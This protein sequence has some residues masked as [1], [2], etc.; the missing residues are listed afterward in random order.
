MKQMRTKWQDAVEEFLY[1]CQLRALSKKTLKGYRNNPRRFFEVM[2]I[3]CVQDVTRTD[4]KR[5]VMQ[6]TEQGRKETYING[7]LKTLRVFFEYLEEEQLIQD[8]PMKGVKNQ[9]GPQPM[10]R[11]LT[12]REAKRMQAVFT[13]RNYL[14][15]RNKTM[16][17]VLLDTGIRNVEICNLKVDDIRPDG[18]IY[19]YGKGKKERYVPVTPAVGKALKRYLR[20]R[21][22]RIEERPHHQ[23]EWL[24]MSQKG[25][26]LTTETIENVVR[27]CGQKAKV[28]ESI[29]CSPHTLRHFYAQSQLMNGMD[30][31][32]LSRLLGHARL[33]VTRIYLNSLEQEHIIEKGRQISPLLS[34]ARKK[35]E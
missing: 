12:E 30:I 3:E 32:T 11:T 23:C 22:R 16:I 15:I 5:Y 27:K 10:I 33:D 1:D 25:K 34:I 9:K 35:I 7:I 6:L 28:R 17:I 18:S 4:V 19:I 26:Q 21:D 24:F 14:E 31:F 13:E 29:R 8:N 20:A 2:E